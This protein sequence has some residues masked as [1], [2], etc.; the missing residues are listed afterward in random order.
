MR[1]AVSALSN[2]SLASAKDAGWI[3]EIGS[4]GPETVPAPSIFAFFELITFAP[5]FRM[6]RTDTHAPL[7]RT[8]PDSMEISGASIL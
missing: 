2:S 7:T 5:S 4:D 3:V 6:N 8:T 1:I